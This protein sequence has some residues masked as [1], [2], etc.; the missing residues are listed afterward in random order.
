MEER[1]GMCHSYSKTKITKNNKKQNQDRERKVKKTYK[2]YHKR[3][4]VGG[5]KNREYKKKTGGKQERVNIEREKGRGP[6]GK[7]AKCERDKIKLMDI[8]QEHKPSLAADV[9]P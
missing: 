3:K 6:C 4:R 8:D 7:E 2:E 5:T 1:G 9:T